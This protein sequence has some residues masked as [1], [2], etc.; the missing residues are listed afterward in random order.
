M[1][2][3]TCDICKHIIVGKTHY[4]T[5]EEGGTA[6]E[7]L[8]EFYANSA[9]Y[10]KKKS[11]LVQSFEICTTCRRIL[12]RLFALRLLDSKNMRNETDKMLKKI[13]KGDV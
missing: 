8:K 13:L 4:V 1:E 3:H 7:E 12:D 2:Y 6:V 10:L 9:D 5:I 11:E